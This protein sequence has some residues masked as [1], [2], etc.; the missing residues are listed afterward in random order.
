MEVKHIH[1]EGN[2]ETRETLDMRRCKNHD[3]VDKITIGKEGNHTFVVTQ[4]DLEGLYERK[5]KE[6][7]KSEI[8]S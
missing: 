1:R 6:R 2:L 5:I 8:P 4:E 3:Y 7:E